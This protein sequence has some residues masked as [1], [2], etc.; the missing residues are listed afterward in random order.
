MGN[1]T[2]PRNQPLPEHTPRTA[3]RTTEAVQELAELHGLCQEGRL[4]EIERWIQ[5]GRPLQV[6]SEA[7]SRRRPS[8]SALKIALE[9]GDHSLVYLLL[10]NGYDPNLEEDSPLDLALRTRRWDL[11]DLLLAWGADPTRADLED[12]FDTY[13]SKLF[14]RFLSMGV[15]LTAGHALAY[16]LAQHTS[17]KP[18]FGFAR[19]HRNDQPGFQ[20]ELNSALA[21]H[22]AEG[23][24]KGVQLSLWAGADPHAPARSLRHGWSDDDEDDDAVS[25]WT[26]VYEA[27]AHGHVEIL[28]KLGPD[29]EL[30]D[31]DDLYR[32]TDRGGI[33]DE[34]AKTR[35]PQDMTGIISWRL[36][37]VGSPFGREWSSLY[38]LKHLF[39]VGGRW[40][41]ASSEIAGIRR[42]LLKLSDHGFVDIMKLLATK[43]YCSPDVLHELGRT[44][45]MRKRMKEVGFIP[46]D[47]DDRGRHHW[48]RPTGAR[49]VLSK[50]DVALPKPP[51]Q[52]LPCIVRIGPYRRDGQE[53]RMSRPQL[54]ELVWSEPVSSLAARWGLSD[55][56]LAK[57]CQRMEI[58]LPP[59][60]YWA[61]VAAGRKVRRPSLPS[62]G[63]GE[64]EEVVVG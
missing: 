5:E 55:R 49:E 32:T 2:D 3:V 6:A 17:N 42:Q 60:G 31:Y 51:K 28:Q 63:K 57:A 37:W 41:E 43:D 16:S 24:E 50:F 46:P 48:E 47:S 52:P 9:K 64:A 15:D 14:E 62:L 44:P 26:A 25:G 22:A 18:L 27:C 4:Y 12:L 21:Y 33:I 36:M 1:F 38:A 13:N 23:N 8:S 7:S 53:V 19:R 11:L 20:A 35:L 30:D 59:R 56:G 34:L 58:P 45:R 39:E 10:C 40:R 29:P 54:F 61:K